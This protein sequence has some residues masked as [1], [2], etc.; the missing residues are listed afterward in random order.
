M[1]NGNERFCR[2]TCR[3]IMCSHVLVHKASYE[4]SFS[5]RQHVLCKKRR[6]IGYESKRTPS[7]KKWKKKII[8]SAERQR[9][10]FE[11]QQCWCNWAGRQCS[12]ARGVMGGIV[13][14]VPVPPL[15]KSFLDVFARF[16]TTEGLLTGQDLATDPLARLFGDSCKP[17]LSGRVRRVRIQLPL[18]SSKMGG[19]VMKGTLVAQKAITIGLSV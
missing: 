19:S 2:K 8:R 7:G 3:G 5:I 16:A 4:C 15:L 6:E 18:H 17:M 12:F 13:W 1:Q 14:E 11:S 10:C 9:C